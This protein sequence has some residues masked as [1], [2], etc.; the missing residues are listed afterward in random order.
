[1]TT[2][3]EVVNQ[4]KYQFDT[5]VNG[6]T[7]RLIQ[8]RFGVKVLNQEDAWLFGVGPALSKPLLDD[9]YRSH[10]MYTGNPELGD[11]GMLAYNYHNQWMETLVA[12]GLPGLALLIILFASLLWAANYRIFETSLIIVFA[13][14][15]FTESFLERQQGVVLFAFVSSVLFKP[16]SIE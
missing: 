3:L 16:D 11:K 14:F 10:N 8:L 7:L 4:E 15:M 1:M 6:L 5:P 12:V 13:V 2:N 9:Q